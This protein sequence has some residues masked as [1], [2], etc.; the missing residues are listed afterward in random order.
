MEQ[1]RLLPSSWRVD[2]RVLADGFSFFRR[3]LFELQQTRFDSRG[4]QANLT[5]DKASWEGKSVISVS[6]FS[7]E[8]LVLLLEVSERMREMVADKSDDAVLRYTWCM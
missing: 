6:Q 7:T 1:T 5:G 4:E 2:P 8:A 3:L